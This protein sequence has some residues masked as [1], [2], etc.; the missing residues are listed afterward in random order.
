MSVDVAR[1]HIVSVDSLCV[2]SRPQENEATS[3]EGLPFD[4]KLKASDSEPWCGVQVIDLKT[5]T[6]VDWFR[7]DGAV[8]EIY[9]VV[10]VPN[11]ACPMS[12]GFASNE[13]QSFVTHE[14]NARFGSID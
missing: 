1:R 3:F 14:E 2:D 11:V 4:E 13:I 9:D 5:G 12:L 10:I 7:I 6:C 8:A